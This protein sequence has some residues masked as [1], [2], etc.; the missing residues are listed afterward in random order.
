[1]DDIEEQQNEYEALKSMYWDDIQGTQEQQFVVCIVACIG[2]P[3]TDKSSQHQPIVLMQDGD[4]VTQF[5]IKIQ[6]DQATAAYQDDDSNMPPSSLAASEQEHAV[7]LTV[8]YIDGYP[9]QNMPQYELSH[10]AEQHEEIMQSIDSAVLLHH[11]QCIRERI[12]ETCQVLIGSGVMVFTMIQ[13]IAEYLFETP[14]REMLAFQESVQSADQEDDIDGGSRT[15]VA[16]DWQ[17]NLI[18]S[19]QSSPL[20]HNSS[21]LQ[22]PS[23]SLDVMV[24]SG[25]DCSSYSAQGKQM[26]RVS[27]L[28]RFTKCAN[29]SSV[30]AT[31]L[32][33]HIIFDR[34]RIRHFDLK[35]DTRYLRRILHTMGAAGNDIFV[36]GGVLPDFSM[37]NSLSHISLWNPKNKNPRDPV[38]RHAYLSPHGRIP[39]PR[40]LHTMNVAIGSLEQSFYVYHHG[41]RNQN[42]TIVVFGGMNENKQYLSDICIGHIFLNENNVAVQWQDTRKHNLSGVAGHASVF[43]KK[44][45]LISFGGVTE[46]GFTNRLI[47]YDA[48]IDTWCSLT[49]DCINNDT[50]GCLQDNYPRPR[51]GHSMCIVDDKIFIHGGQDENGNVLDDL[52]EFNIPHRNFTRIIYKGPGPMRTH[53]A[54]IHSAGNILRMVGG[55]DGKKWCETVID[56][57]TSAQIWKIHAVMDD[58]QAESL[59]N[60]R[61]NQRKRVYGLFS[62]TVAMNQVWMCGGT[63]AFD[64]FPDTYRKLLH[65]IS[66]GRV[67]IKSDDRHRIM[68]CLRCIEETDSIATPQNTHHLLTDAMVKWH[69]TLDASNCDITLL[70]IERDE[71]DG[72]STIARRLY[73]HYELVMECPRI[74]RMIEKKQMKE[75]F[76]F[77]VES[78]SANAVNDASE[79]GSTLVIPIE[80]VKDSL[81]PENFATA[82]GRTPRGMTDQH[83]AM[84]LEFIYTNGISVDS[85]IDDSDVQIL[86]EVAEYFEMPLLRELCTGIVSFDTLVANSLQRRMKCIFDN[87]STIHELQVNDEPLPKGSV[88]IVAPLSPPEYAENGVDEIVQDEEIHAL[89]EDIHHHEPDAS[90]Y[91]MRVHRELLAH[92]S[93]YFEAMFKHGFLESTSKTIQFMENTIR[94]IH[95]LC[96]YMYCGVPLP[97]EITPEICLELFIMSHEFGLSEIHPW[98][99]SVIRDNIDSAELAVQVLEI[100]DLINDA[101][102]RQFCIAFLAKPDSYMAN[103]QMTESL[104]H[105]LQDEIARHAKSSRRKKP[106]KARLPSSEKSRRRQIGWW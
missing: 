71:A 24:S 78:M 65:M 53:A 74:R 75:K 55:W 59:E 42:A 1:M 94:A 36:F 87:M 101:G 73:G 60:V 38:V 27:N 39:T 51:A 80:I 21:Q 34:T 41:H 67:K 30:G 100:S 72:T 43:Y 82:K 81:V 79:E 14:L 26:F 93:I 46:N 6:P 37:T 25:N 2:R 33:D 89:P 92:R 12:D 29:S 7:S 56:F 22:Q 10:T 48:Q 49:S 83:A 97:S 62:A 70:V 40:C 44:Q 90:L 68:S 105:A 9:S 5:C 18:A 66:L 99:R 61:Q 15:S 4:H 63:I 98:L 88:L 95:V 64:S 91:Q 76:R 102:V 16:L 20:P 35:S 52:Y 54:W 23:D 47:M 31:C 11:L 28:H 69:S 58:N 77:G 13:T 57:D 104:P 84:L 106:K 50:R 45:Y 17:G 19:Q 32:D 103:R 8:R 86:H 96:K 85:G 3:M